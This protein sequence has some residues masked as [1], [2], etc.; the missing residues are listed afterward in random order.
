[1]RDV[2][3]TLDRQGFVPL[4]PVGVGAPGFDYLVRRGWSPAH[5]AKAAER[6]W[7]RYDPRERCVVFPHIACGSVVHWTSRT[8]GPTTLRRYRSV[9]KY[10]P[11]PPNDQCQRFTVYDADAVCAG[12]DTLFICEGPL[13]AI[14]VWLAGDGDVVVATALFGAWA[15]PIQLALLRGVRPLYQ[16]VFVMLDADAIGQGQELTGKLDAGVIDVGQEHDDPGA[17]PIDELRRLATFAVTSDQ[18]R[19]AWP[20]ARRELLCR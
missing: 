8:I 18:R 1:M 4:A 6:F 17:M 12:G 3:E 11:E 5:V 14:S 20:L 10:R 9:D 16:R 15:S 7:L 13:D 2:G 19:I